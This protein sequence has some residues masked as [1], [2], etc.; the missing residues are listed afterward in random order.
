MNFS[1][2]NGRTLVRPFRLGRAILLGV[3]IA[4]VARIFLVQFYSVASDSMTP[5]LE[6]IDRIAVSKVERFAQI[7]RGDVVVI[8]GRNSFVSY[9]RTSVFQEFLSLLGME[10]LNQRLFVKRV[11]GIGGDRVVCCT[12][13]GAISVN[14]IALREPY[15]AAGEKPSAIP[16]DVEV[17]EGALW[18][19]GDNRDSSLDSRGLL[20]RPG[21][22]MISSDVVV[23]RVTHVIWPPA[24]IRAV[25]RSHRE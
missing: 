8:D 4:I 18:L 3:V 23:G 11:I 9:E 19:M 7:Q 24:R 17:P 20:G 13:T 15:L 25:E 5:T 6:P 10:N 21:G 14:G 16:F 1:F 22:G 2:R 12:S